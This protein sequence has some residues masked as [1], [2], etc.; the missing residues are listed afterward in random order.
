VRKKESETERER[1]RERERKRE[2]VHFLSATIIR[3][4][5]EDAARL[6]KKE[7]KFF[8]RFFLKGRSKSCS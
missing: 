3:M 5:F 7:K 6:K 4:Q 8:V 1:E 2:I